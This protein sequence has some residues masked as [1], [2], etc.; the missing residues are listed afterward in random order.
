[1]STLTTN[2]DLIKLQYTDLPD[3]TAFNPNWDKIDEML[4]DPEVFIA[5]LD[6]TTNAEI[7]AAYQAGKVM[8][9]SYNNATYPIFTR[10]DA[11]THV[12][13]RID[14]FGIL[15]EYGCMNDAWQ[16]QVIEFAKASEVKTYKLTKSGK[17]IKLDASSG[18]DYTI[19]ENFGVTLHSM[20]NDS[21]TTLKITGLYNFEG[22]QN[23]S[24]LLSSK[25]GELV[26]F[27]IGSGDNGTV[28]K[29]VR[30]SD[31]AKRIK[32]IK[33]SSS[34]KAIYVEMDTW[35]NNLGVQPLTTSA[36]LYDP[37][38]AVESAPDTAVEVAIDSYSDL[39]TSVSNLE[40][41]FR[42]ISASTTDLTAG[43]SSLA[44]GEIYLVYE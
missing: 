37:V 33:Y 35:C 18:T 26:L 24:A 28:A 25:S 42:N 5:E 43:T 1:M 15:E 39:Q 8:I 14:S 7:E 41:N 10:Y 34:E 12:F 6:V 40:T 9:L 13:G 3:L 2:H 4:H 20:N 38:I 23:C 36:E 19:K 16:T 31:G 11:N 27:T 17:E 44:N 32:S 22:L 21:V 30:L 29:A